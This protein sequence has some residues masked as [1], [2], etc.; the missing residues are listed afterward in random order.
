MPQWAVSV[1]NQTEKDEEDSADNFSNEL[2]EEVVEDFVEEEIESEVQGKII[3][4]HITPFYN[5]SIKIYIEKIFLVEIEA[6]QQKID[7]YRGYVQ[8]IQKKQT[9]VM[10]RGTQKRFGQVE[11]GSTV[12]IQIDP[13]DRGKTDPRNVLAVVMENSDGYY[14]LGTKHG[15]FIKI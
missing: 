7:S 1:P 6:R 9:E 14:K 3:V 10:L 12:R 4:S 8:L 11:V 13:V 2:F 5:Y 15:L